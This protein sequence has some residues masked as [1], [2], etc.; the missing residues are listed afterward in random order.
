[1]RH[2]Q[3]IAALE[4]SQ[5]RWFAESD[6][7][8][9]AHLERLMELRAE[10]ASVGHIFGAPLFLMLGCTHRACVVCHEPEPRGSTFTDVST[11]EVHRIGAPRP[12]ETPPPADRSG[13]SPSL[14]P[15][16]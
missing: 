15:Q 8:R 10:C 16:P 1:M 3:V 14:E 4:A 12:E 5:K 9:E 13:S 7:A 2:E 11:G 6:T